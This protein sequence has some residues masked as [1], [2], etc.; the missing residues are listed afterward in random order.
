MATRLKIEDTHYFIDATIRRSVLFQRE[1]TA[2]TEVFYKS[3]EGEI[4]ELFYEQDALVL[5]TDG[6]ILV[7]PDF[8]THHWH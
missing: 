5:V 4:N 7:S 8:T 1:G 2:E 6:G 3:K